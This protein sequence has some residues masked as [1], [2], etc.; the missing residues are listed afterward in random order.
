LIEYSNGYKKKYRKTIHGKLMIIKD[1]VNRRLKIKK[2]IHSFTEEEF[3]LKIEQTNGI[4]PVCKNPFDNSE[5]KSMMSIDHIIPLSKVDDG[6]VY[7]IEKVRPICV[8]CNSTKKDKLEDAN[9]KIIN[10][11][12]KVI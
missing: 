2:V 1:N 5:R 9:N 4:C 11:E 12:A 7:D 10:Q 8:S 3:E 6:F